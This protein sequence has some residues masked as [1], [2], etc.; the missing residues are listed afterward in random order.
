MR[1]ATPKPHTSARLTGPGVWAIA[2]RAG[3]L[4]FAHMGTLPPALPSLRA[5]IVLGSTLA[6]WLAA[7]IGSDAGDVE[8][9]TNVAPR[10]GPAALAT[11]MALFGRW[12]GVFAPL[13]GA[14][15]LG[16]PRV[17]GLARRQSSL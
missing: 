10:G 11:V 17:E 14:Q 13:F 7:A 4:T 3:I 16:I 2:R 12:H 6:G 8:R 1:P 9:T 15:K 5:R